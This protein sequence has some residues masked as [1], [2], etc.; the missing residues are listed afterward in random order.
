MT[1]LR[2]LKVFAAAVV[3]V[4]MFFYFGEDV[5]DQAISSIVWILLAA[6]VGGLTILVIEWVEKSFKKAYG[7]SKSNADK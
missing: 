3:G 4:M 6:I 2:F 7:A 5:S 1:L